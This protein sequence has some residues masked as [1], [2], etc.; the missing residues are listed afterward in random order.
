MGEEHLPHRY[1]ETGSARIRLIQNRRDISFNSGFGPSSAVT[2][3]ASS[4][5]R[6]WGTSQARAH[7]LRMHRAGVLSGDR[8]RSFSPLAAHIL[9]RRRAKFLQTTTAAKI[10]GCSGIV[11]RSCRSL[12][13][14]V[15]L[16]D[17]VFNGGR[18]CS[19]IGIVHRRSSPSDRLFTIG[20]LIIFR[21]AERISLPPGGGGSGW[22]GKCPW[23]CY[24]FY[25]THPLSPSRQGRG[26]RR[27]TED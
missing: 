12:R 5:C 20:Y 8:R 11:H 24:Y 25:F 3:L 15:H 7:D 19:S 1:H 6:R 26:E 18:P 2:I 13:R 14:N 16:T 9:T 21:L 10:V 17:R 22:G 23:N 27:L 4:A